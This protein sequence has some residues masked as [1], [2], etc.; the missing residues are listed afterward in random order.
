MVHEKYGIGIYRGL[1][2]IEV[3]GALK[4][5]LVIEYAE[6]GKLYVLASETDRIQK[7]RSKES[8]APKINRLGGSE[9][10]K[11]RNKVKGHVSEVAQHLVKLYSERQAREGFAYSPDS[12]WQKEFEETFPYTETDDQL[13]AI[14]DVKADMESHK[15][16][17]RL[18]CGDVGFGKTEVAIRAA[19]KAVG[20]SKQVAYLVPTTILAEQ[21]YETFTERMKDYPVTVRLL[22]RFCTQK[23][24]KS[25][26]RELKE[27]KVDIVIGTHRLLSKDVE[28]S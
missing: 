10:Q 18:V 17:D 26:L 7:Y 8:R 21:H 16:M 3:D 24:I 22:C 14:E 2:K 19:F 1:E 4:D 28:F 20:D 6:G 11:V 15:I 9:W 13:K 25:T 23:E 12:E 27:G 5:Y